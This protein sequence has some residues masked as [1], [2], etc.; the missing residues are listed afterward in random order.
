MVE[1]DDELR[2]TAAECLALAQDMADPSAR[3]TL[4]TMAQTLHEMA[5]RP[6]TRIDG[7]GQDFNNEQMLATNRRP[8]QQQQQIQPRKNKE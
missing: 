3:A 8:V 7:I 5:N 6:T 4:V 1:R 2:R